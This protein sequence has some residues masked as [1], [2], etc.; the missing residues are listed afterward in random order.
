MPARSRSVTLGSASPDRASIS[1]QFFAFR[2]DYPIAISATSCLAK[3][4]CTLFVPDL[5]ST[6][7]SAI[8]R[9]WRNVQV[10]VPDTTAFPSMILWL[11]TPV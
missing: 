9:K 11:V 5:N 8:L 1:E 6:S 4:S 3:D 2:L 7:D 10:G